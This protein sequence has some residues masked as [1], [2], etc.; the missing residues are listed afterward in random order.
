MHK[1]L[2]PI[3]ITV[4]VEFENDITVKDYTAKLV[5]TFLISGNPELEEIFSRGK[6]MS[7]KSVHITPLFE[8][9]GKEKMR[10]VY[11]YL[12]PYQILCLLHLLARRECY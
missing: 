5:K 7:P 4:E 2:L 1:Y 10:A 6:N 12:I 8:N 3:K 11:P 9:E